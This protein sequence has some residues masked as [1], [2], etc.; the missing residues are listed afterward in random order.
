MR[1]IEEEKVNMYRTQMIM[2]DGSIETIISRRN[3]MI[4]ISRWTKAKR[5][6]LEEFEVDGMVFKMKEFKGFR[7]S[8][9]AD[10]LV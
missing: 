8:A 3:S 7:H 4:F 9:P 10:S 5:A 2:L 6:N 1:E